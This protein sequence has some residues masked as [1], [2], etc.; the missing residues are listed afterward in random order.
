MRFQARQGEAVAT[1]RIYDTIQSAPNT[2]QCL[3]NAGEVQF[4]VHCERGTAR[5][6]GP[7]EIAWTQGDTETVESLTSDRPDAE[8]MLDHF[9]RRVA[10]GLIPVADLSDI[11]KAINIFR[12]MEGSKAVGEPVP[13]PG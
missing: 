10:G 7:S 4:D 2:A 3:P 9:F 5:L 12:A 1:I 11:C 8:V 6:A 13:V